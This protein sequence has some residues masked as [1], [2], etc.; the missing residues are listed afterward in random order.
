MYN[1]TFFKHR[2]VNLSKLAA[3]GFG[4]QKGEYVYST[5]LLDGQFTM[6]VTVGKNE[7]PKTALI[8]RATQDEYTLHLVESACGTFVGSVRAEYER[9]LTEIRDQCFDKQVFASDY[10]H[11]LIEYV[12]A[13][14]GD[15]PEYLWEKF[16]ANAV[17][18]RKDNK[19]WYGALLTVSEKKLGVGGEE[20]VEI[21]DLR[22]E[23]DTLAALIDNEKYFPGYH[24]N[25]RHWLTMRLD[26]SAPFDE[27]CTR[28]DESYILAK[29]R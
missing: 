28:L 14:Y 3:F 7:T 21:V 26:G 10:A 18:R 2:T 13:T 12:K 6:T 11:R 1:E 17:W 5:P 15:E 27:I 20:T 8:D 4:E 24:M 22:I 25:K 9:V 23:P 29:G 19:K 16:P